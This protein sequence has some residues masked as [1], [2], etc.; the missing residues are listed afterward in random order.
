ML[1]D[2]PVDE[3]AYFNLIAWYGTEKHGFVDEITYIW[4]DNKSSLTRNKTPEQYF[5]EKHSYYIQSQIKAFQFLFEHN[6]Q[7]V[8]KLIG[9]TLINLYYYY[10]KAKYY[11]CDLQKLDN[12]LYE[13]HGAPRILEWY[14]KME[15]WVA[16]LEGLKA[17]IQCEDK[18][19][20]FF[21]EPFSVWVT[22]LLIN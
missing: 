1:P 17:G 10:M 9:D 7:I 2:L 16:I 20:I 4:R 18:N 14:N 22:R 11:G 5:K 8:D 6:I 19:I 3:D 12:L 13:L 15:N 21:Q